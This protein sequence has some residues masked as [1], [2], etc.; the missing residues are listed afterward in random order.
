MLIDPGEGPIQHGPQRGRL[1]LGQRNLLAGHLNVD[2]RCMREQAAGTTTPCR[3]P[4]RPVGE[5]RCLQFHRALFTGC[6]CRRDHLTAD[7]NLDGLDRRRT[8]RLSTDR[9]LASRLHYHYAAWFLIRCGERQQR[10]VRDEGAPRAYCLNPR[11][12]IQML[13]GGKPRIGTN[14][15]QRHCVGIFAAATYQDRAESAIQQAIVKL[16]RRPGEVGVRP[17][18]K[19]VDLAENQC[20]QRFTLRMSL[21][22]PRQVGP[23]DEALFAATLI[24]PIRD[25][26][27]IRLIGFTEAQRKH[28]AMTVEQR[29]RTKHGMTVE[30]IDGDHALGGAE[31]GI[32]AAEG[33]Q[34]GRGGRN[35]LGRG[36]LAR[37]QLDNGKSLGSA[38]EQGGVWREIVRP[39]VAGIPA[40]RTFV[41]PALNRQPQRHLSLGQGDLPADGKVLVALGDLDGDR[42][43][44]QR[45]LTGAVHEGKRLAIEQHLSPD[46]LAGSRAKARVQSKGRA[47]ESLAVGDAQT[48]GDGL[49][50]V[51]VSDADVNVEH[52]LTASTQP[53]PPGATADTMPPPAPPVP[54]GRSCPKSARERASSPAT[55]WCAAHP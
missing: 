21:R 16:K 29:D 28:R 54:A 15:T 31:S 49:T 33:Q 51:A 8:A 2:G 18:F 35:C 32:R 14:G 6:S 26:P 9:Y 53:P 37:Q 30:R 24:A 4:G 11:S 48:S 46:V 20:S 1:L 10:P 25:G 43:R 52:G 17:D 47:V 23:D 45:N 50:G 7:E 55:S 19:G 40:R 27:V 3:D 13:I 12:R 42:S 41:R 34:V 39:H 44:R 5:Q 22:E 36:P 38:F